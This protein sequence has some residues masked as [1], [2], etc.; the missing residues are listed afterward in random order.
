MDSKNKE[1]LMESD[2]RGGCAMLTEF[3]KEVLNAIQEDLPLTPRPFAVLA[4]RLHTSEETLLE[5]LRALSGAGYLRR[6]GAF[7]QSEALGYQGTLI[8][9]KVAPESL[10]DAA[11]A[12]NRYPGVTH[13]YE[14]T[15][16]YNLW[17]TLQAPDDATR[18]KILDE[19]AAL[20]GVEALM[21]LRARKKYKVRVR[22]HLR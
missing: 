9:L 13:N 16:R 19:I 20:P 5:R 21:D 14:R 3:D 1:A 4:E 12:V 6:F 11:R 22:F 10:P 8:A 2:F 7:F 17:F 15:G 18:R